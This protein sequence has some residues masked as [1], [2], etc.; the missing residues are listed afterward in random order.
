MSHSFITKACCPKE[1]SNGGGDSSIFLPL[2][3]HFLQAHFFSFFGGVGGWGEV[4]PGSQ[5]FTVVVGFASAMGM[6]LDRVDFVAPRGFVAMGVVL[7]VGDPVGCSLG[8][9]AGAGSGQRS[10]NS[11][12]CR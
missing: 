11:P 3:R 12:R 9:A 10:E 6:A 8:H 5:R 1:L 7:R 2:T 4:V